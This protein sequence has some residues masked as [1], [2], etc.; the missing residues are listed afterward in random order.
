MPLKQEMMQRS[1]QRCY[2]AFHHAAKKNGYELVVLAVPLSPGNIEGV[3]GRD[4][5][6]ALADLLEAFLV[7][8][9]GS[10][11]GS[12]EQNY[13]DGIDDASVEAPPDNGGTYRR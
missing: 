1:L 3:Y 10:A 2:S 5:E 4:R 13:R 8:L 11:N 12:P 7:Q 9:R 6:T